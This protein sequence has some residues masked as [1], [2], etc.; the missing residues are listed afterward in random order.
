MGKSLNS[1]LNDRVFSHLVDHNCP[2]GFLRLGNLQNHGQRL[3]LFKILYKFGFRG[4]GS[5]DSF[6]ILWQ[7][8]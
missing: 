8:N 7:I 2:L 5:Q 6:R 4:I 1:P 3:L